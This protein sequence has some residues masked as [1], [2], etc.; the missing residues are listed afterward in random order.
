YR[1]SDTPLPADVAGQAAQ[2]WLQGE[3]LV[4]QRL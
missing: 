1:T 3:K 2:V 4:M